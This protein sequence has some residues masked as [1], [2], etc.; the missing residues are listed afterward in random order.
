[1]WYD[2]FCNRI[3]MDPIID[4]TQTSCQVPLQSS[5]IDFLILEPLKLFNKK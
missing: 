3:G 4:L 1:M 5:S 2:I